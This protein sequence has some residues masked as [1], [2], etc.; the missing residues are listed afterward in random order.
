MNAFY[1]NFTASD[2]TAYTIQINDATGGGDSKIQLYKGGSVV[3][4]LV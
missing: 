4:Y 1:F 2:G 3:W